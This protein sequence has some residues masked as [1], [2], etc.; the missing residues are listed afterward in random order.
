MLEG[1]TSQ[2]TLD[3]VQGRG[4]DAAIMPAK[5]KSKPKGEPPQWCMTEIPVKFKYV[6]ARCVPYS[7]INVTGK[8]KKKKERLMK[9]LSTD[10]CGLA[11]L[12][13]PVAK[14]FGDHLRPETHDRDWLVQQSEGRFI[15][16]DDVH[17]IGV[18]CKE[19]LIYDSSL[20]FC[21]TLYKEALIFC[22]IGSRPEIRRIMRRN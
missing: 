19:R 18:D 7:Y 17:C 2:S 12:C 21:L 3:K 1:G 16:A 22:G 6:N 8:N 5:G 14:E 20:K 15:V 10:L 9:A 4:V 13:G 11:Q